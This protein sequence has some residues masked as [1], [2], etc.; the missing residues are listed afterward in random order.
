MRKTNEDD[1]TAV[2]N[3]QNFFFVWT[4]DEN[5]TWTT[6]KTLKKVYGK[7]ESC[8]SHFEKQMATISGVWTTRHERS[9]ESVFYHYPN[10]NVY[11]YSNTL[12]NDWFSAMEVLGYSIKVYQFDLRRLFKGTPLLNWIKSPNQERWAKVDMRLNLL[13]NKL[14]V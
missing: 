14:T 9:I 8:D 2:G 3:E 11:V 12:P 7:R 10:A 5:S 1:G 6:F 13:F 4:T